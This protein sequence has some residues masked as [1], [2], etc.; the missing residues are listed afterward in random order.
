[1]LRIEA[2]STVPESRTRWRGLSVYR[3]PCLC[4]Q[5]GKP[6]RRN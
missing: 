4:P 5:R 1:L 6:L 3:L 2:A